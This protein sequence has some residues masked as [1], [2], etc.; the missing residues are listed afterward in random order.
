MRYNKKTSKRKEEK[1]LDT[2]ETLND[3]LVNLFFEIL[4]L[5]ERELIKGEFKNISVNDMH[6]MDAIGLGEGKNMSAIAK[7]Q[8]VTIGSLS[9]SMNSLVK[10]DYV[11]RQRSEEDRR[12]VIIKLTEKGERAFK[13]HKEFHEKMVDAALDYLAEDEHAIA[14]VMKVLKGVSDFFGNF[15]MEE[16]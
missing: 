6:I 8:G 13:R 7:I 4:D 2:R 10:K 3:I 15:K 16:E 14:K 11:V 5:E 9:T 1:D 12:V